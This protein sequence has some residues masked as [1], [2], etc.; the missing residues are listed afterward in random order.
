MKQRSRQK[1]DQKLPDIPGI[2]LSAWGHQRQAYHFA[3]DL[4][5]AC[6]AMGMGTGKSMTAIGLITNRPHDMVLIVAPKSVISVWPKEFQKHAVEQFHI[7]APVKG[8]VRQKVS[9]IIKEKQLAEAK[10]RPFVLIVNYDAYWR[11]PLKKWLSSQMWD[12][13]IYDECHR[14]KAPKG[15]A[16]DFASRCLVDKS[17]YRLGLTGTLLPH[18]PMDV[19]AQYKAIDPTVFGKSFYRF[20]KHFA[21]FGGFNNKQIIDY[22]NQKE[23]NAKIESISIS[24]KL[25]RS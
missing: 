12:Q 15:K 17:R 8:S 23:L 2:K 7:F 11:E 25:R 3:K 20:Q 9:N 21:E 18:S 1:S 5:G 24:G 22:K 10:C 4:H 14:I 19:F 6:L 16:S 13:I